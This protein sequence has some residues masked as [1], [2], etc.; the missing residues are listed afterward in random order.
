MIASIS[1]KIKSRRANCLI[2][3]VNGVGYKVF[4]PLPYL[5]E[6]AGGQEVELYTYQHIREDILD[7]FGFLTEDELFLFE[8]LLSVSSVGPKSALSFMSI[9][10]VSE[11]EKAILNED[12]D[13]LTSVSGIGKKTAQRVI[14]ELKGKIVD[15]DDKTISSGDREVLEGLVNLG[16]TVKEAREVIRKIPVDYQGTADRLKQALKIMGSK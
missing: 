1:G 5:D 9:A 10:K 15:R 12:L 6:L 8:K 7:L 13:F 14:L 3:G 16:Y 4:V 2:V 11:L